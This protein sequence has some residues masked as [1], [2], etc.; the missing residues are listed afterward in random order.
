MRSVASVDKPLV[1]LEGE[2]KTPPFSQ[3]ARLE[4][5][6][7]LRKLQQGELLGMPHSRPMPSIGIRC[8]ELRVNDESATWRIIYRLDTDAIVI[9][10]VFNKKSPATPRAVINTCKKR[11][12]D[13]ENA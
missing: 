5:G 11:L 8:H 3:A 13:Y 9:L 10:E 2:I 6:Y 4:A 7:L 12:K 1:W